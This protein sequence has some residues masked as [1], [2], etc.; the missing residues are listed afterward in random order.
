MKELLFRYL[1][2]GVSASIGIAILLLLRA[3]L[4]KAPKWTVCLLW[5]LIFVQL[6]IP[7]QLQT[8]V[9]LVPDGVVSM[10]ENGDIDFCGYNLDA[11]GEADR[12]NAEELPKLLPTNPITSGGNIVTIDYLTIVSFVWAIL[13]LAMLLYTVATYIHLKQKLRYAHLLHE[14]VYIGENIQSPF[15]F[16]YLHPRIYL[17]EGLPNEVAA[18]VIAHEKAHMKRL[19]HWVML[20]G[21]LALALHWYNPLVWLGYAVMCRDLEAAC[22]ESVIKNMCVEERKGYSRAILA[23][24]AKAQFGACPLA[25]GEVGIRQRIR[26]I[27]EFRKKGLV[28][29]AI[30]ICLVVAISLCFLTKPMQPA[31]YPEGYTK[32]YSLM[33]QDADTV[34]S[35]IGVRRSDAQDLGRGYAFRLPGTV[36]FRGL[37]LAVMLQFGEAPVGLYSVTYFVQGISV[38]DSTIAS[39][40]QLSEKLCAGMGV[41]EN[42]SLG[43]KPIHE[44]EDAEI[45]KSFSRGHRVRNMWDLTRGISDAARRY[46]GRLVR[47]GYAYPQYWCYYEI[48]TDMGA[49]TV[50]LTLQYT[51]HTS[52][53]I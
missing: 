53:D 49:D 35:A 6:V 43:S 9:S 5:I 4:R 36:H 2:V 21:F 22:D 13:A 14:S 38:N 18:H 16:G 1:S 17:P 24:Q 41:P 39:F 23:C 32:L 52:P 27:L 8:P 26:G 33:G 34:F 20:I 7:Y 12:F 45:I 50:S 3:V 10:Y 29:C 28:S 19:D 48:L 47:G 11:L 42:R 37:D 46:A 51:F 31:V 44:M 15:L 30:T 40:K 25:F